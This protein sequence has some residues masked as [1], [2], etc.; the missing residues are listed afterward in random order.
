MDPA[1]REAVVFLTLFAA[2]GRGTAVGATHQGR[3]YP[4]KMNINKQLLWSS[5][6]V[7]FFCWHTQRFAMSTLL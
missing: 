1:I 6:I 3:N 4:Q 2:A 7:L 5:L